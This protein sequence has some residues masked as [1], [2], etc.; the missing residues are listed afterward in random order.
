VKVGVDPT[1]NEVQAQLD[2]P[3]PSKYF[4]NLALRAAQQW[5]FRPPMIDGQDVSSEWILR[6]EFSRTDTKVRPVRTSP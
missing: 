1:G 5:K 3:G 4:A 6:F 2:S